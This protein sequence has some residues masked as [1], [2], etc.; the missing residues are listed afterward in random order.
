MI[1][2][3]KIYQ[4]KKAKGTNVYV[5]KFDK[6]ALEILNTK[7]LEVKFNK[8]CNITLFK[9]SLTT[10]LEYKIKDDDTIRVSTNDAYIDLT[11]EY[12]IHSEEDDSLGFELNK[13]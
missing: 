8:E 11:G 2:N 3:I 6:E 4:Q 12:Y 1:G 13:K 5:F 9:P 7:K 10:A